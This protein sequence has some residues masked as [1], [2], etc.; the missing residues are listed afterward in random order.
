MLFKT[1]EEI[2]LDANATTPVLPE[3]AK[4]AHEAMQELFGNPS[5]N[6]TSGLRAREI[7]ESA[8]RLAQSVLGVTSDQGQIIFTSGATEAI[9]LGIFSC[10]CQLKEQRGQFDPSTATNIHRINS[11]PFTADVGNEANGVNSPK[12]FLLYGAT[13]H[14]AVPQ[15]L[16]HWNRLLC[17]GAEVTA[18]PVDRKGHLDLDF[19]SQHVPLADMV[20]TMA[21]NNETGVITDLKQVEATIR[22]SNPDVLWMVDSVQAI[23]KIDMRLGSTTIDY[24][25]FSGHKIYAPKGI[26]ILYARKSAPIVPLMAGGGQEHGARGGTENLPGVAAIAAVLQQLTDSP[27]RSFNDQQ[28]LEDYRQRLI[29]QLK[30]TFPSLVLNA[31]L[32]TS[33]PTTINF[34]VQ[35]FSSKELLDLFDAAGIRVSSGSAC[36]SEVVGSYVLEA[37]GLPRWQSEGA[38]RL[39]FGPLITTAEIEAAC[40]QIEQVGFALCESCLVVAPQASVDRRPI[41][42]LV[43]L[44]NGSTC[45]WLLFDAD[46]ARCLIIDPLPELAPRIASLVRCQESHAIAILDTHAHLDHHSCRTELLTELGPLALPS[47]HNADLLGWPQ[48]PDGTL[49]LA[50]QTIAPYLQLGNKVLAQ[51]ELPGHTKISSAYLFGPLNDGKLKG[52]LKN[53]LDGTP[54]RMTQ[55]DV[56]FAFLGDTILMGGLGRSD[57]PTS[58]PDKMYDSLKRISRLINPRTIICPTHD[59]T[60]GFATCL[61]AERTQNELLNRV[62]SESGIDENDFLIRKRE[63][64]AR[65]TQS[66]NMTDI[67]C[68][69]VSDSIDESVGDLL[70]VPKHGL[71]ELLSRQP[72]VLIVDVREPHEFV[73]TLDWKAAGFGCPPISIPLTRLTG[74]IPRLQQL[75]ENEERTILF[76]CRSGKRSS[77]AAEVAWRNGIRSVGHVAGGLA[78]HTSIHSLAPQSQSDVGYVI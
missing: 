56:K 43:Q 51:T 21:I 18:I 49:E 66:D 55:S 30:T 35:G 2:Y 63:M 8:R 31:P 27:S 52:K 24:A 38:I 45:T 12:R 41:D 7:L 72:N 11:E 54:I 19:L 60:N 34:S 69:H 15:A 17:F 40:Q 46:S 71:Q 39:S 59:Y 16:Q 74:E 42:G 50:D 77:K 5:S 58:V 20:C 64:D 73:F 65:I 76:L 53:R 13:E 1:A 37:M 22:K 10:L 29:A 44:K 6:H 33:A 36:G 23:G 3:A 4:A 26:G 61:A 75:S 9:Q 68:G 62:L 67:I 70:E 48:Q 32:D 78:L 14:K 57:F 28:T 25:P 47:A